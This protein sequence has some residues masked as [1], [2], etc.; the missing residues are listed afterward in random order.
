MTDGCLVRIGKVRK[1]VAKCCDDGC[2]SATDRQTLAGLSKSREH[3]STKPW[4]VPGP[5]GSKEPL[6]GTTHHTTRHYIMHSEHVVTAHIMPH[7]EAGDQ[8]AVF[9]NV[10]GGSP[11]PFPDCQDLHGTERQEAGSHGGIPET[12]LHAETSRSCKHQRSKTP[13]KRQRCTS[14]MQNK[15]FR[16]NVAFFSN[17]MQLDS[18][19]DSIPSLFGCCD[20]LIQHLNVL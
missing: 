20:N 14:L 19:P 1:L 8:S 13:R 11:N 17:V 4:P 16:R 2:M 5:N 3:T 7:L 9:S 10:V 12:S 15:N 6:H 18:S